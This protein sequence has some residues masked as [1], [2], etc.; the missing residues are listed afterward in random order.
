MNHYALFTIIKVHGHF[1][2]TAR[3]LIK[4]LYDHYTELI[5][6]VNPTTIDTTLTAAAALQELK[7]DNNNNTYAKISSASRFR[8]IQLSCKSIN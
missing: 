3:K 2:R 1:K 6:F 8:S 7:Y 5:L 4:L